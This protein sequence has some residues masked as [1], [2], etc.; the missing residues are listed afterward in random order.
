ML[1]CKACGKDI[2]F[3]R[4]TNDKLIPVDAE[5]VKLNRFNSADELFDP[6][7]HVTHFRTC[8]SADQF[9]KKDKK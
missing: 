5:T 3:L 1:K 4:T 9:R 7:R 2:V 6:E 8:P